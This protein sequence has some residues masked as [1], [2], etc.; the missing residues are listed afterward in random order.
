MKIGTKPSSGVKTAHRRQAGTNRPPL[1]RWARLKA[2]EAVDGPLGSRCRAWL[3][4]KKAWAD[5]KHLYWVP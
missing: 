3:H 5:A 1:K 4:G 2:R